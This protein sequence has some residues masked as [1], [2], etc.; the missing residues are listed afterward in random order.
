MLL[1]ASAGCAGATSVPVSDLR[2]WQPITYSCKDTPATRAQ[3][4]AHDSVYDTLKSGR[5]TVNQDKCE[6]APKPAKTS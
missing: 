2:P 4:L 1:L 3:I 6:E 5:K